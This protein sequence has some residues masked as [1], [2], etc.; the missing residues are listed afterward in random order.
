MIWNN[1][2]LHNASVAKDTGAVAVVVVFDPQTPRKTR[3]R[4]HRVSL[5]YILNLC[6]FYDRMRIIEKRAE[7]SLTVF[8][9][10]ENHAK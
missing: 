9:V 10:Y 2:L 3:Y 8:V 5:V 7:T 4:A 1:V 6:E